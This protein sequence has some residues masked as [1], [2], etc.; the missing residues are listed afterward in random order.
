MS[1]AIDCEAADPYAC[2]L[3]CDAH[4]TCKSFALRPQ[5][6]GCQLCESDGTSVK[7]SGSETGV[8]VYSQACAATLTAP[9]P[10]PTFAT[11]TD[12]NSEADCAQLNVVHVHCGNVLSGMK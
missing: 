3:L 9:T 12:T 11:P 10:A 5:L 6:G 2:K 4:A 7:S 8:E 1:N